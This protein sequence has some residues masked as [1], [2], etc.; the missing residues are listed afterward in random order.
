[1]GISN[2]PEIFQQKMN[3][4][5]HGFEFIHAYIDKLLVLPKG[6]WTDYVHKLE[7]TLIKLNGKGLKYNIENYLFRQ[8]KRKYLI[9]LG[10]H[11]GVKP[12]D[13]K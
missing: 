10:T 3:D 5:F 7:L 6:Y 13:K 11:D 8:T 2:P 12:L 9:F 4:L 1:M